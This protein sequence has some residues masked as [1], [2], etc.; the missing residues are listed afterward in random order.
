MGSDYVYLP[1]KT[2]DILIR[3][4]LSATELSCALAILA[5]SSRSEHKEVAISLNDFKV[6]TNRDIETIRDGLKSL[7]HK[8]IIEQTRAATFNEPARWRMLV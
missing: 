5:D 6:R 1:N 2:L 7:Q 3:S 4:H 8:K